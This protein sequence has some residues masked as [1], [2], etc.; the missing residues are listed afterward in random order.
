MKKN[1]LGI[2]FHDLTPGEAVT[3]GLALL[4]GA[5]VGNYVVTPNP[6]FIL[7]ARKDAVFAGDLAGAALTLAD[8]VGV[9]YAAKILGTPLKGKVPGID[10]AAGLMA[11]MAEK[12]QRLYLLGARP[13]VAELAAR[14]LEERFPGL[15]VCGVRDGYF[16]W[17][18]SPAIAEEIRKADAHGVFVC[19]GAPKQE[20]WMAQYGTATG[21]RLLVGLGGS[22]DVFAG[23][24][25]RAP[26]GWQRLGLE[27]LYRLKKEP[28]RW[29][30]MIR[31][32]LVL[33]YAL[34]GRLR[35]GDH[36]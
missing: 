31:L 8:G 3:A 28:W 17:E 24:V 11:G 15:K 32:P 36:G 4:N 35:G 21:A 22:L 13:G 18:D 26:E 23:T 30:R 29:K 20:R 5:S 25:E 34:L 6:E 16:P 7:N 2:D 10:F 9:V 33:W 14:N 19:L 12:G 1:I 27:W